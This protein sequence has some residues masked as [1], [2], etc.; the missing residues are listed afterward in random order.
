MSLDFEKS[1]SGAALGADGRKAYAL[2]DGELRVFNVETGELS[3]STL[4]APNTLNLALDGQE[5][6][7]GVTTKDSV[8]L[9]RLEKE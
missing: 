4:I 3:S 2:L 8:R 1:L 9:V 5:G 6:L 7:I